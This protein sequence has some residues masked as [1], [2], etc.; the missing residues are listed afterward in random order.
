MIIAPMRILN[1]SGGI[2]NRTHDFER[3]R[4]AKG[5]GKEKIGSNDKGK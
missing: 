3:T 2:D 5:K 1:I 4:S